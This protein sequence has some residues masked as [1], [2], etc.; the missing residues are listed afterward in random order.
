MSNVVVGISDCRF[1]TSANDSLITYAL[2]S[3]IAVAIYDPVALVGGL[4]HYLLPDSRM[5]PQKAAKMPFVFADTGIP[6]LFRNSYKLG[7]TKNRLRVFA[8]GGAQVFKGDTF[9][10]GRRNQLALKE[11]LSFAGVF[12]KEEDLGGSSSRTIRMEMKT[13]AVFLKTG[14][15]AEQL[16]GIHSSVARADA[17]RN[18]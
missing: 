8:A 13:G 11:I 6:T 7:A 5:D 3:C 17:H 9:E 18:L 12:T 16:M 2:G 1:S 10:I 15:G 4:L 14:G